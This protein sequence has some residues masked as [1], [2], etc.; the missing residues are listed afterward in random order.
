MSLI[1]SISPRSASLFLFIIGAKAF[2]WA[3]RHAAILSCFE[4]IRL[5][6]LMTVSV[7]AAFSSGFNFGGSVNT[8]LLGGG[9]FSMISVFSSD[10]RP[11][12]NISYHR[13]AI[14]FGISDNRALSGAIRFLMALRTFSPKPP[15][16]IELRVRCC[17]NSRRCVTGVFD[18][19][20]VCSSFDNGY[21]PSRRIVNL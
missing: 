16:V 17:L 11:C 18:A 8:Q 13:T 4:T 9:Y 2:P 10:G 6:R 1:A 7:T 21:F 14:G 5:Y 19:F 15:R 3:E 12:L 20:L